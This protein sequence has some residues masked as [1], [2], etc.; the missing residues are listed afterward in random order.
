MPFIAQE[1]SLHFADLTLAGLTQQEVSA[2][3]SD[4]CPENKKADGRLLS[5][6][7]A[8]GS[9][10]QQLF[11]CKKNLFVVACVS[12]FFYSV[13]AILSNCHN[14]NLASLVLNANRHS[15]LFLKYQ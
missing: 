1:M 14:M 8:V 6:S 7:V 5:K 3:C 11:F 9:I 2:V 10:L 4:V 13:A 15:Y 12:F